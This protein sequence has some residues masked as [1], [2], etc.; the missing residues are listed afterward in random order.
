MVATQ[1]EIDIGIRR[2]GIR[3]RRRRVAN[4]TSKEIDTRRIGIRKGRML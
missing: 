4:D 2:I 3:K 1:K